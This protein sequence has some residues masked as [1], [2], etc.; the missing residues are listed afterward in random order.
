MKKQYTILLPALCCLMGSRA[1]AQ[2]LPQVNFPTNQSICDNTPW[3]LIFFDDFNGNAI[4]SSKWITFNSWKN[5]SRQI[6][7][8]T[9]QGDHENWDQGRMRDPYNSLL[10]DEN[11]IVSN[12]TVKLLARNESTTWDCEACPG[13]ITKHLSAAT[14][15]IPFNKPDGTPN[16]FNSGRFEFRAR[17]PSFRDAHSYFYLWHGSGINEID[18]VEAFGKSGSYFNPLYKHRPGSTFTTYAWAP[19]DSN[20]YQLQTEKVEGDY[21]NQGWL[22]YI[23]GNNVHLRQSNWHTYACEWDTALIR[24]YFNGAHQKTIWKYYRD[25]TVSYH[26]GNTWVVYATKMPS[27]C[28]AATGNWKITPGYP[29]NRAADMQ[30]RIGSGFHERTNGFPGQNFTYG[31]VEVDYV[32]I[33]QRHPQ[34]D[35]HTEICNGTPNQITGPAT[36]CGPTAYSLQQWAPGGTWSASNNGVTLNSGLGS[37]VIVTA[38]P[39]SSIATTT[40]FYTYSP[41]N[42]SCPEVTLSK[43]INTGAGSIPAQVAVVRNRNFWGT[44]QSFQLTASPAIPGASYQWKIWFGTPGM[45]Q[46]YIE[47]TGSFVNTPTVPTL[48]FAPYYINWELKVSTA[49][50][51]RIFTGSNSN[52]PFASPMAGKPATYMERDSS[53]LYL[54]A[55]FS[56]EDS[57]Q[58]EQFVAARV[59]SEFIEDINDTAAIAALIGKIRFEALEP[60]LYFEEEEERSETMLAPAKA[61]ASESKVYPNPAANSITVRLSERFDPDE[62]VNFTIRNVLSTSERSGTLS[63]DIINIASLAAGNYLLELRQ[64]EITEYVRFVKE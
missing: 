14:I 16:W 8:V 44:N 47:R 28:T 7:G 57:V 45:N 10:R 26:N 41:M 33:F 6:N 60:Y 49:C 17:F 53:A 19:N 42:G 3:K 2:S 23:L 32:K 40:L 34:D 46:N 56:E 61:T 50:G 24:F 48:P 21:P 15:T 37:S 4:D 9:V 31:Q 62:A 22:D 52:M 27:G 55:R 64:K 29:Y 43:V 25:M 20:I 18:L 38:A 12:G 11:I 51:S 58:Y 63:T 54:E 59:A 30:F 36:L 5:M 1:G 35:G 13:P 39:N